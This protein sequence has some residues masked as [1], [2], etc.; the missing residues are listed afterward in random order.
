[1]VPSVLTPVKTESTIMAEQVKK[2]KVPYCQ[3]RC[4]NRRYHT[5]RTGVKTEGTI[6][7]EKV[8]KQ[9]VP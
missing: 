4:K 3:N 7:P 9:K 1:M 5:A 6:M 8:L 2:Q